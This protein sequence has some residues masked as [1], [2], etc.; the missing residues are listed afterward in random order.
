MEIENNSII[1]KAGRKIMNTILNQDE[2]DEFFR[3]LIEIGV[4]LNQAF[5]KTFFS[6]LEKGKSCSNFMQISHRLKDKGVFCLKL[7][8]GS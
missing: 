4:V 8:I 7:M 3:N 1:K 6:C 2:F 5:F